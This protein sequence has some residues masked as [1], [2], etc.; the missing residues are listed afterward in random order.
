[1]H[2][3]AVVD[4]SGS[5]GTEQR[6][7]NELL[8]DTLVIAGHTV[9]TIIVDDEIRD[10]GAHHVGR[11]YRHCGAG[12]TMWHEAVRQAMETPHRHLVLL[13]DGILPTH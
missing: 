6:K 8:L 11:T 5:I 9:D 10:L 12:S 3:V 7:T 13:T 2:I 4:V 1:M